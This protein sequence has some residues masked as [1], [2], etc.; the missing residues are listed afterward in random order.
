MGPF[1]IS[2]V[3]LAVAV[4]LVNYLIEP[5]SVL[6]HELGHA[7]A[8]LRVSSGPVLVEVGHGRTATTLVF[9][10]LTVKFSPALHRRGSHH[11]GICRWQGATATPRD[12]MR[13]A[14]AGP[15]ATALL[16]P[17]YVLG[18]YM[19]RNSPAWVEAVFVLS[20]VACL[21][22]LLFNL[23]PRPESLLGSIPTGIQKRDGIKA[24]TAYRQSRDPNHRNR[25]PGPNEWSS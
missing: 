10:R 12:R 2:L 6:C 18:A 7:T 23:D 15:I 25:R 5:F 20:A 3:E 19:T 13:V 1:H 4:L 14:L 22:G 16:I 24:R 11:R 21:I 17:F 9:E 8:A